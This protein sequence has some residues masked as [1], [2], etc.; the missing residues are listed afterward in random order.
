MDTRHDFERYLESRYATKTRQ[1]AFRGADA[2]A[3]RHWQTTTRRGLRRLLT[4]GEWERVP[5]EPRRVVHSETTA[6]RRERITYTVLPG[7]TVPAW[8]FIPHGVPLPAPAVLCP[9]GHGMGMN[10]VVDEVP[11][12]YK[13]YPLELARRGL[14]ALVPE[15]LGF[16]E[17][18]GEPDN[19]RR[20]SHVYNYHVLNLL[21]LSQQGL[22][23]HNLMCALDV[24]AALPEVRADR[25]GCYGLSLGGETTLLLSALDR[26]IRAAC[27]SG[28]LCSY[29][30]CFLDMAHCG[31]GYSF[32]L[33]RYL[34]MVDLATLIAPRPLLLESAISDPVF[35][36]D[37]AKQ[38]FTELQ[39]LY[40]MLGVPDRVAQDVFAGEH[41]ISGA[42]A[43]DWLTRQ[44]TAE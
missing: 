32:A 28:F 12:I 5:P 24:L 17:R 21:G 1:W 43:Y 6:Y 30:S 9:P 26:R 29:R 27:V 36:L 34:E 10:Q 22:F 42:V 20:S 3:L 11:G 37:D 25:I 2:E 4:L 31:C 41:E 7:V 33:L 19:D 18:A 39:Q 23:A 15:H 8:L 44:L 40:A 16:G 13:Q 35:Y 38:V 14:V